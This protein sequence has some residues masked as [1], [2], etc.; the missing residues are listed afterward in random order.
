MGEVGSPG[1]RNLSICPPA[2]RRE[3]RGGD[4]EADEL[5]DP[6]DPAD[7]VLQGGHI[8]GTFACQGAIV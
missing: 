7:G 5:L 8:F 1:L 4:G 6:G 2:R 3:F